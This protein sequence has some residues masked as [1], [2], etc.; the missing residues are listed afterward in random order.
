MASPADDARRP[1]AATAAPVFAARVVRRTQPRRVRPRRRRQ[2]MRRWQALTGRL[3]TLLVGGMGIAALPVRPWRRRR[4]RVPHLV[5]VDPTAP[6]PSPTNPRSVTRNA[7]RT[8]PITRPQHVAAA[9]ATP[10]LAR[11]VAHRHESALRP[12]TGRRS[13]LIEFS[14][15]DT[16]QPLSLPPTGRP[17]PRPR[18]RRP[19][20]WPDAPSTRGTVSGFQPGPTTR[21]ATVTAPP[22]APNP[23]DAA[24]DVDP[25]PP[26]WRRT[27][28][29]RIHREPATP[30]ERFTTRL[31]SG[32]I[33]VA[34]PLPSRLH[35]LARAVA[36]RVPRYRTGH[37][38][39]T[40]LD[41]AGAHAA[42]VDGTLH[43]PAPP[44]SSPRT[45]GVIAHELSHVA[46][47][48]R[49]A[50][51]PTGA[52]QVGRPRFFLDRVVSGSMDAG[53]RQARRLGEQVHERATQ[54]MP[55]APA[56][57]S[58]AGLPG[59][60]SVPGMSDISGIPGLP[61]LPGLPDAARIGDMVPD[62]ASL[63]V[64][65]A[66]AALSAA[67]QALGDAGGTASALGDRAMT[68]AR[69]MLGSVPAAAGAPAALAD[70]LGIPD[71]LPPPAA[72]GSL[73][74]PALAAGETAVAGARGAAGDIAGPIDSVIGTATSAIGDLDGRIGI[75]VEALE[76]RLLAELERRGGRYAGVF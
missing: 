33:G 36:G 10:A 6:A 16:H 56:M 25:R 15:S 60:P 31:T 63:P 22:K 59:A 9:S 13:P 70:Q 5:D 37:T 21:P 38:V 24:G 55:T 18:L 54:S 53:E 44:D 11:L 35:L 30:Q 14:G 45:L 28:V 66:A 73:L 4:A 1:A 61:A 75:L 20:G 67:R 74:Q 17:G 71:E 72:V 68:G 29:A 52:G 58:L 26:V 51:G 39:R 19:T 62:V 43:L 42:T 32:P 47:G 2:P 34:Q 3:R 64:G 8:S 57:P 49:R 41:A 12:V 46:E 40:A 27:V 23:H 76:E 50:H 69:D 7:T 65:G 48:T